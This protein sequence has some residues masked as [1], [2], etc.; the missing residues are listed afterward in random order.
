MGSDKGF[1]VGAYLWGGKEQDT[2][3][4]FGIWICTGSNQKVT[5]P[6]YIKNEGAKSKYIMRCT[7]NTFV[8]LIQKRLFPFSP[9][10]VYERNYCAT[11]KKPSCL[12]YWLRLQGSIDK[13]WKTRF[14]IVH[15]LSIMISHGYLRWFSNKHWR[16]LNHIN[17]SES[18]NKFQKN[19][20]KQK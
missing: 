17:I 19:I 2:Q 4:P 11:S 8:G 20:A 14:I 16:L 1:L 12:E 5:S 10:K 18:N 13:Y 9:H 15:T 3:A 6:V 7:R